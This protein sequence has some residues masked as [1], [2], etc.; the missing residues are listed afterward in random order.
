MQERNLAS[1]YEAGFNSYLEEQELK[2]QASSMEKKAFLD[3]FTDQLAEK[4]SDKLAEGISNTVTRAAFERA[5]NALKGM[6]TNKLPAKNQKFITR[7]MS[8]DPVLKSR[9]PERVLSHYMTMF[10]TAPSVC[11][12]E[13]VVS[14]FLKESTS[15][16]AIS[17]V[18]IKSL[19]DLEKTM[20]ETSDK[21]SQTYGK[22]I[23]M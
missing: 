20:T 15:Y 14:S 2:K 22:L 1:L 5:G 13:N 12:D 8:I 18:T 6:Q 23:G 17:T 4:F 11:L 21:K 9:P 3:S 16:D 10:R 19:V 7:L